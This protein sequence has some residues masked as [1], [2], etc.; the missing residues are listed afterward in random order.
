MFPASSSKLIIPPRNPLFRLPSPSI[1]WP[2][3]EYHITESYKSHFWSLVSFTQCYTFSIY[4]CFSVSLVVYF[5]CS[6]YIVW[7]YYNLFIPFS[8]NGILYCFQFMI[9]L[10]KLFLWNSVCDKSRIKTVKLYVQIKKPISTSDRSPI[11]Q[12]HSL[13]T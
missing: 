8:N 9:I 3:L 1:V 5:H 13:C 2:I 11:F 4:P 7:K 10:K 12:L 6:E